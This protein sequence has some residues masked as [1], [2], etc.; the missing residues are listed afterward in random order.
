[1]TDWLIEAQRAALLRIR[2][3]EAAPKPS[4]GGVDGVLLDAAGL[5]RG[6]ALGLKGEAGPDLTLLEGAQVW[7]EAV[8]GEPLGWPR[9]ARD[10]LLSE[11][12]FADAPGWRV[13]KDEAVLTA[14][15]AYRVALRNLP[16][17]A[18]DPT[19]ITWPER[20]AT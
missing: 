7:R 11:S 1:M 6:V 10:R 17:T 8:V 15:D 19:T 16:E 13:G 9:T 18:P 5:V 12:D 4:G 20:P 2:E 14:W 3:A